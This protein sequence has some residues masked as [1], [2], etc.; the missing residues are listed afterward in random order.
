[1]W[2]P[3]GAVAV[4][5]LADGGYSPGA[6]VAFGVAALAAA[7]VT[8]ARAGMPGRLRSAPLLALIGLALLGA[9]S[10]LW[11][12][13]L[14]ERALVWALVT[15]GYAAV[16]VAAH[17][18]AV[19]S[20]GVAAISTTLAVLA[21]VSGAVGLV[22]AAF[23]AGPY[24]ELR[25]GEW[26]PGGPFQYPPAL[27]L[28]QVSALPAL[29]VGAARGGRWTAPFAAAGLALAG[30]VLALTDSR[31]G[32]AMGVVIAGLALIAPRRTLGSS[33][34]VA[35][36]ALG[37]C[38]AGGLCLAA[39]I[40]PGGA[41]GPTI[42]APALVALIAGGLWPRLRGALP[43]P[44][45]AGEC[46]PGDLRRR[47]GRAP[48]AVGVAVVL[49]AAVAAGS[50]AFGWTA[51]G[52]GG[53][54][55]GRATTWGAAVETFADDPLKGAGADAFLAASVR[56]QD[57]QSVRF[58]H[59]LPLELG[60]ELGVLGLLAAAALYAGSIQAL[61]RARR[62]PAGWLLGP[63]VAAFLIAGLLDWPWH[64]AGAGGIWALALGGVGA[65]EEV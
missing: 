57:G 25:G 18:V 58:A 26:R 10:A 41:R 37:A 3:A 11:T 33:R 6:R 4:A 44:A 51:G 15:A 32:L 42:A 7:L 28:L 48:V 24:A 2:A 43:E 38:L 45:E 17:T 47:P 36:G 64:L 23:G 19:R 1:M 30:G 13:G 54:L 35:L 49:A 34:A 22:A 31:T 46:G 12:A 20:G 63:A 53:F 62:T 61:L 16:V 50:L 55:H 27:A 21:G 56:H 39:W 52:D 14:T 29:L 60:A 8:V 59:S 40:G 5:V 65:A 9:V